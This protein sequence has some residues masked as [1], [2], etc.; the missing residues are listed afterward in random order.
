MTMLVALLATLALAAGAFCWATGVR[1][2]RD[3]PSTM[4]VTTWPGVELEQPYGAWDAEAYD[5]GTGRDRTIPA[6]VG[7]SILQSA[8]WPGIRRTR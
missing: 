3:D 5:A 2:R 1:P 4:Y 8:T 7:A 6:I